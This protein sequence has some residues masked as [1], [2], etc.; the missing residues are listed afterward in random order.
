MELH[1]RIELV[2]T[3]VAEADQKMQALRHALLPKA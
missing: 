2:N 3:L 1:H